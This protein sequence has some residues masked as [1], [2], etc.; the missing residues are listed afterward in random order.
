MR[1]V[2]LMISLIISLFLTS[3]VTELDEDIHHQHFNKN[4]AIVTD[5]VQEEPDTIKHWLSA[6]AFVLK[7]DSVIIRLDSLEF[8]I[9]TTS[10][11]K[12]TVL[13]ELELGSNLGYHY[14]GVE[15]MLDSTRIVV[16]QQ[17]E[18]SLTVQN[19]GPHCDLIHWKHYYSEADTL[20]PV[21][22][23]GIYRL[24]EAYEDSLREEFPKVSMKEV[25]KI[26]LK[27]CGEEWG[28]L[29]SESKSVHSYPLAV[30]ISR[31][32]LKILIFN[33]K[34]ELISEKVL[35]FLVPM[36]C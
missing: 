31:E 7:M 30:S 3:C 33:N 15:S 17:F 8:Y 5:Q 26:V 27:E 18:T 20:A 35:I 32:I 11:S 21:D 34:G 19:E 1:A 36:G 9:D 28:K 4:N 6:E 29:I 10:R 12:D 22:S 16:L 14:F 2:Y 25:K 23:T 13:F 24:K